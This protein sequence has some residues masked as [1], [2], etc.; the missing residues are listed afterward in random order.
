MIGP[1]RHMTLVGAAFVF[2]AAMLMVA[3]AAK[4]TEVVVKAAADKREKRI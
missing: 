3:I 1:V 2:W 4:G